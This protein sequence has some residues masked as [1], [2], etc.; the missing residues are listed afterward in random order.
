MNCGYCD[1]KGTH[2]YWLSVDEWRNVPCNVCNAHSHQWTTYSDDRAWM[3]C[4]GCD[5]VFNA[6]TATTTLS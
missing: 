3:V 1:D 4:S 5:L 2:T 6:E